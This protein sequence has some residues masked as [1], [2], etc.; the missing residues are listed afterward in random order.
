M[1]LSIAYASPVKL[2]NATSPRSPPW[3][4]SPINLS[5]NPGHSFGGAIAANGSKVYV[6]WADESPNGNNPSGSS[7][8]TGPGIYDILFSSSSNSGTTY[9]API[10][11]S[12]RA[13]MTTNPN[14]GMNLPFGG[15]VCIGGAIN[16][17]ISVAASGSNI[18]VVWGEGT[19][20]DGDDL[21]GGVVWGIFFAHSTDGGATFSSPINFYSVAF[22]NSDSGTGVDPGLAVSGSNV[23]ISWA[24]GNSGRIFYERSTDSGATFNGGTPGAAMHIGNPFIATP[25]PKIASSGNNVYIVWKD[26]AFSGSFNIGGVAEVKSTDSG[27]SFLPEKEDD[28]FGGVFTNPQLAV[29]SKGIDYVVWAKQ[30]PNNPLTYDDVY[31]GAYGLASSTDITAQYHQFFSIDELH[32][33][34]TVG[35]PRIAINP[36]N[37]SSLITVAWLDNTICAPGF[38]IYTASFANPNGQ[39]GGPTRLTDCSVIPSN[40]RINY[41]N[42]IPYISYTN[43]GTDIR[44]IGE[45]GGPYNGVSINS[46]SIANPNPTRVDTESATNGKDRV[47]FVWHDHTQQN[48]E[49]YVRGLS[50]PLCPES[51]SSDETISS[52]CTWPNS[53]RIEA[54]IIVNSGAIILVPNQI[55]LNIDLQHFHL[56]VKSGGGV[57]VNSGGAIT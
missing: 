3:D 41:I 1:L 18:Y 49:V 26:F 19:G 10:D 42:N 24:D 23:Y 21:G 7:C 52:I 9:S 43:S 4:A 37:S 36:G 20:D 16:P 25:A 35:S 54:N 50:A 6:A 2:A 44:V 30:V 45:E 53:N 5:N 31:L 27:A 46:T 32:I 11:L 39:N 47:Y 12:N 51:I 56:I 48:G 40:I 34:P 8:G 15:L 57:L 33:L 29:D 14:G 55:H 17:K 38:S 22:P 13:I 28:P